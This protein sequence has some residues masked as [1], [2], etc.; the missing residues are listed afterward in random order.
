M[1]LKRQCLYN[2][3]KLLHSPK[4]PFYG[5][6]GY[7]TRLLPRSKSV[8]V[9]LDCH[10][11]ATSPTGQLGGRNGKRTNIWLAWLQWQREVGR[12]G[13]PDEE[14]EVRE[15]MRDL[16]IVI[17]LLIENCLEAAT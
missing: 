16:F 1:I 10:K 12:V 5:N 13:Q 15:T 9:T 3:Y 7:T 4:Q 8:L 17:V 6:A 14:D 2:Y 11:I